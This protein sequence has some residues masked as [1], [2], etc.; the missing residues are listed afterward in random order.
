[1]QK[2]SSFAILFLSLKC[3]SQEPEPVYRIKLSAD[4]VQKPAIKTRNGSTVLAV[5]CSADTVLYPYLKEATLGTE[6]FFTDAMVGNIR[7][8][9]QAYLL[10]QSI[11]IKGVKFWGGAYSTDPAFQENIPVVVSLWSVNSQYMPVTEIATTTVNVRTG[12]DWY[13]AMFA[14]PVT[15]SENYALTVR[16]S[17]NDTI[18]VI[19]NN[20]GAEGQTPNYGEALAWR[21]F[22]SGTWNTSASF[23]GQDLEY[24][25]F[26]ITEYTISSGFTTDGEAC[27]G[28]SE[29]FTNTS[30]PILD[31]RMYN[32]RVFDA[33][34]GLAPAD[35]TFSWNY[36]EGTE[37]VVTDGQHTYS[38]PGSYNVAL[39]A[40]ST[41]YY[42]NCTEVTSASV[43]VTACGLP[44]KLSSFTA[45][46]EPAGNLLR[47]RAEIEENVSYYGIERS[48]NGI[49]FLQVAKVPA[50]NSNN[51][52]YSFKDSYSGAVSFYRLRM[53]DND[54][55]FSYSGTVVVKTDAKEFSIKASSI[56]DG[57][58][59]LVSTEVGG[60]LDVV[61]YNA[62]GVLLA[63]QSFNVQKG[64]SSLPLFK[65]NNFAKGIYIITA[66]NGSKTCTIRFI[67]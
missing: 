14:T 66:G 25:I 33:Y 27:T 23:F 20:A 65:L 32:L 24:M 4:D 37:E 35:L 9:S 40:A 59:L 5:S 1:M 6:S 45:L 16:S 53:T 13:T 47:W 2:L 3:F 60:N 57:V 22:G 30:S 34:W 46:K 42:R 15:Q 64:E 36:G 55:S 51:T 63:K 49:D 50:K 52:W 67:R 12:S 26:P 44:V 48:L 61:I 10:N 39:A 8:A 43:S 7:T 11:V 19:T 56:R 28:V 29:T 18:S 17:L 41:G 54:G 31:N 62:T 38:A 21:K 58:Q